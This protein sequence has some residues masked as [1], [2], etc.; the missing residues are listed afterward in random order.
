MQIDLVCGYSCQIKCF[1]TKL[2]GTYPLVLGH[3][4]LTQHNPAID[5]SKG[6]LQL[7]HQREPTVTPPDIS[8]VNTAAY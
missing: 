7:P 4:W 5:W 3:D 6:T 1:V 2:E 8:F